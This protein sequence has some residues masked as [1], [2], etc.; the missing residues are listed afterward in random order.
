M[1]ALD[2]KLL[3]L[4]QKNFPLESRPYLASGGNIGLPEG[5]VLAR[6]KRFTE[7]GIL[8][9]IGAIF[10]PQAFG[11]QTS[12]VAFEV[13]SEREEKAAQIINAHPGVSH[14][15]LRD[16]RFNFWFTVA[17]PPGKSLEKEVAVFK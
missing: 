1:Q 16:H 11:Y 7:E 15:Y 6:L 10:N 3:N 12:L 13:P 4:V 8:R 5:E 9:Q 2:R 17:V 14:N